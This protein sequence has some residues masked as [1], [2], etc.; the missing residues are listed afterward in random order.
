MLVSCIGLLRDQPF[1]HCQH[2]TYTCYSVTYYQFSFQ[3]N[4]LL[5]RCF[6]QLLKEI[7]FLCS[8]FPLLAMSTFS[9]VQSH[10]FVAWRNHTAVFLPPPF[11]CFQVCFCFFF[12]FVHMLLLEL[13]VAVICLYLLYFKMYSPC[14]CINESSQFSM[15]SC[16]LNLSFFDTYNLCHLLGVRPF[17][18]SH[19]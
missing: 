1:H 8:C 19:P 12:L 13:L 9:L 2:I 7:Q 5:W 10:Q 14:P 18:H 4:R 16:H 6:V 17:V 15:L 3:D 11:F